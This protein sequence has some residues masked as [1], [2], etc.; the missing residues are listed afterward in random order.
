MNKRAAAT[1]KHALR[2]AL[3][4]IRQRQ[5]QDGIVDF[6]RDAQLF[7]AGGQDVQVPTALQQVVGK[8]GAGVRQ[9]LAV[10]ED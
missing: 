1:G 9:V 7:T 2:L 10:V 5:R 6:A 3:H 4:W 8:R